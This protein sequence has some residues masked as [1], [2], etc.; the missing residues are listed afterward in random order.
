MFW[1]PKFDQIMQNDTAMRREM[2]W[3]RDEGVAQ[4]WRMRFTPDKE[5]PGPIAKIAGSKK[6]IYEQENHLDTST[7]VMQWQVFPKVATDKVT[8]K[9][10]MT[11]RTIATGVERRVQGEVRVQ[12][13]LIGGRIEKAI[14][15]SVSESYE[16]AAAATHRWIANHSD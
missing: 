3:K 8:A 6:L 12:I 15:V 16:K 7:H 13:P 10:T 1:D 5:L 14:L 2:L 11:V 4:I 9:G